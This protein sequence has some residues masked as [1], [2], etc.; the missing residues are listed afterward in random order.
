MVRVGVIGIGRMGERHARNIDR[1]IPSASLAAVMDADRGRA[2]GV[3]HASGA[4]VFDDAEELIASDGVDAVVI[5]SPNST[6]A[7]L[8]LICLEHGK[9]ALVEKPLASEL[10]DAEAVVEREIEGQQRLLQVGFMRHY[11]PDHTTVHAAVRDGSIGRALLF[12]GWHRNPP[13]PTPPRSRDLLVNS[14]IHDLESARW[15]LDQEIREVSVLGTVI[16]PDRSDQL[17]L[18]VITL[19]MS[20]GSLG[21]IEVNK[22]CAVGYEVGVEIT[23]SEGIV[24]TPPNHAPLL[25]D[26]EEM[27]RR[28]APDWEDRFAEAYVAEVR[29]WVRSVAEGIPEG[30][31]AWDGYRALAAAVAGATSLERGIPVTV[32]TPSRP[33]FYE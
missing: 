2:E 3:A 4:L 8:A 16:H 30:P 19:V 33:G 18:Q 22:D 32:D 12:R 23:G 28:V 27:G 6:H 21:V 15:L 10:A 14:A 29:A 5:A 9:P 31:N 1:A 20:G 17:H 26:A 13:E 11:D 25:R 7:D 24:S